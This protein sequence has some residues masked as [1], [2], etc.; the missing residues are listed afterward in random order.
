[1]S[2]VGYLPPVFDEGELLVDGGYVN[3]LPSDEM[4]K[5]GVHT[6]IAVDVEDKDESMYADIHPLQVIRLP[7]I[8]HIDPLHMLLCAHHL[9]SLPL[10]VQPC[11]CGFPGCTHFD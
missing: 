9:S 6:I 11:D 10:D 8:A 2:V 5:L 1:M 4:Q 3:N 7:P